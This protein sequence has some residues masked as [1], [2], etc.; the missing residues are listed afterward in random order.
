MDGLSVVQ[1]LHLLVNDRKRYY[2]RNISKITKHA[3]KHATNS[4][5]KDLILNEGIVIGGDSNL[6]QEKKE[7]NLQKILKSQKEEA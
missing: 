4:T 7:D 5:N 2:I 1:K 3:I 6:I